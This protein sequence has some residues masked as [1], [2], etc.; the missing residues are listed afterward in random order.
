MRWEKDEEGSAPLTTG[1]A[2]EAGRVNA[3]F[4]LRRNYF[5]LQG[6]A[7]NKRGKRHSVFQGAL[8]SA[9]F[10]GFLPPDDEQPTSYHN[11]LLP[12]LANTT[13]FVL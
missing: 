11:C 9:G 7:P 10:T 1:S 2:V 6:R 13:R 12:A 4:P 3:S 8:T 5:K